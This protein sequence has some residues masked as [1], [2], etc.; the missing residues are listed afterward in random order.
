MIYLIIHKAFGSTRVPPLASS[1]CSVIK[2]RYR[3]LL[4]AA[5]T[6]RAW[7]ARSQTLL[8]SDVQLEDARQ[9]QR[10]LVMGGLGRRTRVL[11]LLGDWPSSDG[12]VRGV[13]GL[14]ELV[15]IGLTLERMERFLCLPSLQG[16][17]WFQS[18]PEL[19]PEDGLCAQTCNPCTSSQ[20]RC[21]TTAAT[22]PASLFPSRCDTSISVN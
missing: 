3:F 22:I 13:V 5:L 8:W 7:R 17:L 19:V 4:S 9:L 12:V 16:E 1:S 6:A 11:R 18:L 21:D 20:R 14:E 2:E 15:L 10:F